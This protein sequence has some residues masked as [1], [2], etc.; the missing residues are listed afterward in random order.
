MPLKVVYNELEL[1][2]KVAQ[3]DEQ[4]F[5]SIFYMFH[6]E[7]GDYVLRLTKSLPL[8]E[9][10]VQDIFLKLWTRREQL[11]GIQNFRAYL[12]TATRNHAFNILRNEARKAILY[13][14]WVS[15]LPHSED[16]DAV[17]DHEKYYSFLEAAIA[18]LAPQQQKVWRM[19][20]EDGMKHEE[21]AENLQLSKETVKR[22][23]S[24]AMASISRYV[25]N[26]A[27]NVLRIYLIT[28]TIFS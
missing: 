28:R 16:P 22:H 15:E 6:Q 20:R 27:G 10:I 11:A 17:Q 25:K 12:F 13:Q 5:S 21:I 9:E 1:L 3:G 18:H 14:N 24:L 26:N 4:A 8:T 19:S 23:I 2:E 7:L